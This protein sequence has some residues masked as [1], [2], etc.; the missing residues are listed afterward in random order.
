MGPSTVRAIEPGDRPWIESM[1]GR[2]WGADFV[3]AHG[4]VFRPVELPGFIAD[5]G[6]PTGLLTYRMDDDGDLE[7]VTID[8]LD[9]DRGTGTALLEAAVEEARR[10][11]S[12]R[13]WLITT[14]DNLTG[15]AFYQKRGFQLVELRP[16]AVDRSRDLK[17][18]IPLVGPS[19]I[20]IRDELVLEQEL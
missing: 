2:L 19:G 20:P 3:V 15:L 17:P 7:V 8:A 12:R 1:A 10:A 9:G 4:R 13:V 14:N 16:G 6:G 11:G 5:D 18:Q